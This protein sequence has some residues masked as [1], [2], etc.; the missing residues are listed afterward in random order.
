MVRSIVIIGAGHAG[1][2][3]ALSLAEANWRGRVVLVGDECE[4]PYERP[5]VSK[6]LLQAD[7]DEGRLATALEWEATGFVL[8]IGSRA[9][10]I[11]RGRKEVLLSD[12]RRIRYEILVLATG[13]RPRLL[14]SLV[15]RSAPHVYLRTREDAA[16]LRARLRPGLRVLIIGGGVIGLEAASAVIKAGGQATVFEMGDNLMGRSA[17]PVVAG[18]LAD[19]HRSAGVEVHTGVEIESLERGSNGGVQINLRDGRRDNGDLAIIGIGV[20]PNVELAD[21]A[22]LKTDNGIL[23]DEFGCTSDPSI[24]AIGDVARHPLGEHGLVRQE[25]WRHAENH[26]RA[27]AA[28]V[29]GDPIPYVDLPGFW[30]DQ[31]GHRLQVEGECF[32][33]P[34]MR[35][36]GTTRAAFF[37]RG[38]RLCG[39]AMLDSPRGAAMARKA[40][41]SGA[42]P[43][44][45][46]LQDVATPLKAALLSSISASETGDSQNFTSQR[47]DR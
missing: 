41:L 8:E 45:A 4:L 13:S 23:V 35:I 5:P 37:M 15:D 39:C 22:G 44:P 24:L 47:T 43:N 3:F 32:G 7:S 38:D 27:V 28:G 11:D 46:I 30:S 14:S 29:V 26:A 42:T 16:W 20:L 19:I 25:T 34:L 36:E 6:G 21:A 33:T 1:G 18:W 9:L 10:S 31:L 40:I 2:R 17:P 12:G